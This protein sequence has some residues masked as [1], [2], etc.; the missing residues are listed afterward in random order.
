[1]KC[2]ACNFNLENG[3]KF[4]GSCGTK[5]E[6]IN[7]CSECNTINDIGNKFCGSCGNNLNK[8]LKIITIFQI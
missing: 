5:V 6:P 4:C 7:S 1:M 8:N 2:L 3:N